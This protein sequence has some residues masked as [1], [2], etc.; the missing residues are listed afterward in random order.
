MKWGEFEEELRSDRL[1]L[2]LYQQGEVKKLVLLGL[3]ATMISRRLEVEVGNIKLECKNDAGGAPVTSKYHLYI[4]GVE[5]HNV[6]G[7]EF[8]VFNASESSI[9]TVQL[10]VLP[11]DAEYSVGW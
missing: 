9:A 2:S 10:S 1:A 4:D 8:P 7:V 11:F 3:D 6:T 5:Q